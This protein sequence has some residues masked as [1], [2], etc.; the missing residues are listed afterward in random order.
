[1]RG[2]DEAPV[3]S[4]LELEELVRLR[5][6]LDWSDWKAHPR[7]K[8]ERVIR[9]A[10][11]RWGVSGD[12]PPLDPRALLAGMHPA[13]DNEAELDAAMRADGD[14][15]AACDAARDAWIDA[16]DAASAGQDVD[17]TDDHG[18]ADEDAQGRRVN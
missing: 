4:P 6:E 11:R 15:L 14:F 12:E 10:Q 18:R 2:Y 5:G 9:E 17:G 1:M 8:K 16:L 3:E 13:N 7:F